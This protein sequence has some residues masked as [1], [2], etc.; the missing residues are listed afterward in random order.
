M[1]DYSRFVLLKLTTDRHEASHSLFATAEIR[2]WYIFLF[3]LFLI[4]CGMLSGYLS[5]FEH[6]VWHLDGR[7]CNFILAR[8]V[9]LQHLASVEERKIKSLV[10][11]L[12]ETQMKKLEIKLR[13]FEELEAIMDKE[14]EAVGWLPVF[15]SVCAIMQQWH[16]QLSGTG[17]LRQWII[18]LF[19]SVLLSVLLSPKFGLRPKFSQNVKSFFRLDSAISG[20]FSWDQTS[21]WA[22]AE[23]KAN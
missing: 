5:I 18:S 13:H 16:Y 22:I 21:D 3:L 14:R 6:I 4:S 1:K 2:V 20:V 8:V 15:R 17:V 10:A 11:L 9:A 23:S 12:V 19:G 7:W